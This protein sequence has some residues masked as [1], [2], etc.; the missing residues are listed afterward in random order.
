PAL[1][2]IHPA[3]PSLRECRSG[4]P[5]LSP[6]ICRATVVRPA[7]CSVPAHRNIR[8]GLCDLAADLGDDRM[9]LRSCSQKAHTVCP[10]DADVDNP[11]YPRIPGARGDAGLPCRPPVQSSPC[12]LVA[13]PP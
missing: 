5:G 1:R 11:C 3:G 10:T 4:L 2:T 9:L 7:G 8:T 6:G 13:R 12:A